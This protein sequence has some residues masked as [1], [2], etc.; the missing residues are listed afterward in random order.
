MDIAVANHFEKLCVLSGV[1][2]LIDHGVDRGP[3]CL[4]G[5]QKHIPPGER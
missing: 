1:G 2:S 4:L 5:E 3:G